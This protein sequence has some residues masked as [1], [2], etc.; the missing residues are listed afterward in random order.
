M[1]TCAH[2]KAGQ[3]VDHVRIGGAGLAFFDSKPGEM[4]Q[5]TFA[6]HGMHCRAE[7]KAFFNSVFYAAK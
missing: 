5:A 2:A 6:K 7:R 3:R 1:C 4:T